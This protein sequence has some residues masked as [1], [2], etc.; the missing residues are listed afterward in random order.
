QKSPAPKTCPVSPRPGSREEADY[1]SQPSQHH[2]QVPYQQPRIATAIPGPR[3]SPSGPA[4][5]QE[6]RTAW[7]TAK[8]RCKPERPQL[9]GLYTTS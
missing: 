4:L 2:P 8:R 3:H 9:F 1:S 5:L 6:T 7:Q